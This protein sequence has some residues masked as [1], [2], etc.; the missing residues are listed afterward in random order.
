MSTD[1]D[2]QHAAIAAPDAPAAVARE[3]IIYDGRI[4]AIAT[5]Q[6][7]QYAEHLR[8]RPYEDPERQFVGL[9]AA[10]AGDVCRGTVTVPYTD[11]D[12]RKYAGQITIPEGLRDHPVPNPR[13]TA[14]E[15][16]IPLAELLDR[17]TWFPVGTIALQKLHARAQERHIPIRASAGTREMV[18]PQADPPREDGAR[19]WRRR[20]LGQ[21]NN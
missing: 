10:Y 13:Q 7:I 16:G 4:A 18:A 8:E 19:G 17:D 6:R 12:A 21:R 20:L 11:E 15:L 5:A 14:S 2:Q 3:L 9:M 1:P